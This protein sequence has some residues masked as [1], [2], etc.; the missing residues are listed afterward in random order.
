MDVLEFLANVIYFFIRAAFRLI[1]WLA[2]IIICVFGWWILRFVWRS[3]FKSKNHLPSGERIIAYPD[4]KRF[5]ELKHSHG[6]TRRVPD[7]P[8]M[9]DLLAEQ[10]RQKSLLRFVRRR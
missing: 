1:L 6:P 3:V 9:R 8:Q 5:I 7:T 10:K 2:F 4:G